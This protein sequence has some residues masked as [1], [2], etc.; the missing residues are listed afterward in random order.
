MADYNEYKT[1]IVLRNDTAEKLVEKDPVLLKG[2]ICIEIDTNK[3]KFGD[4]VKKYSELA[5]VGTSIKV[6]GEGDVIVGASV[7]ANGVLVLTK[8]K[9]NLENVYLTDGFTFTKPVGTV[10]IPASGSTKYG[11]AN[12]S[13]QAFFAGLFAQAVNP[14]VTQPSASI[15]LT[16]AGAKEAGTKVTPAYSA[17]L[18]AGSY[19]YGPATGVTAKTYKISNGSVEKT[20]ASGSFDEIQVT[21]DMN[22]KL[23]AEIT[24][25]ASTKAPLNNIGAEVPAL[26]IAAGTKTATSAAITSYRNTFYGSVTTKGEAP[27]GA[28]IRA[29]GNKSNASWAKGKTFNCPEA[30]GAMR[31]IIAVPAPLTCTS[32]KDVNGLNAEAVSAFTHI[33]VNVEGANGYEAKAYNVY[34]KDNAAAC[35]KANNWAVTLG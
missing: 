10:T 19:Q 21:D 31:V 23:T 30:V 22:Y 35:D 18:T 24:Y 28:N 4:G 5:Y 13:L 27:T 34:Y 29:L 3:F 12:E 16:G 8:G 33:T 2:E 20:T 32:I 11:E 7:D 25:D 15:S 17:S 6:E 14:T 26:K 1:K 9:L